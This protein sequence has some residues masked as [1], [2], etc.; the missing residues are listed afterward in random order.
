MDKPGNDNIGEQEM[1]TP[2]EVDRCRRLEQQD[3]TLTSLKL[4]ISSYSGAQ[5]TLVA[6]KK[7]PH[8]KEL[9]IT[10]SISDREIGKLCREVLLQNS[11]LEKLT[12]DLRECTDGGTQHLA[13]IIQYSKNLKWLS[14]MLNNVSDKGAS[15]LADALDKSALLV[16]AIYATQLDLHDRCIGDSGAAHFAAALKSCENLTSIC[17]AQNAVSNAGLEC[18]LEGLF[19][20]VTVKSLDLHSNKIDKKGAARL[21]AFL[22]SNTSLKQLILDENHGISSEGTKE[23]AIGLCHNSTLEVL[24]LKSCNIGKK[25]AERFTTT[26]SQNKTL[27]ELILCGNVE[28]GDYAVELMSR[29]LRHN[30]SLKKLDL[31]SCGIGDEGCSHLADTLI[32]NTALVHLLLHRNEISDGGALTLSGALAKN[33]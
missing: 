11:S 26:F 21:A 6:L 20:N 17:I 10:S 7:S 12:L 30:S 22:V 13:E 18:I 2:T 25:G 32:T 15:Y 5:P 1:A 14:L 19:S 16:F 4:G 29:G 33:S 23:L 28:I 9:F 27:K 24:S 3:T 31:S 8:L